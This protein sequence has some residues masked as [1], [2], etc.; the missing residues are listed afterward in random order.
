MCIVCK[1]QHSTQTSRHEA[2]TPGLRRT[3]SASISSKVILAQLIPILYI[4]LSCFVELVDRDRNPAAAL[5]GFYTRPYHNSMHTPKQ[6]AC[7]KQSKTSSRLAALQH[8]I[9]HVLLIVPLAR[10]AG[11]CH[12]FKRRQEEKKRDI[13]QNRTE[14]NRTEQS[15]T[16]QQL[17]STMVKGS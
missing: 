5:H 12:Q 8:T 10:Y 16:E 14:Q 15:K 3:Y 2:F 17:L 11:K 9:V 1:L 13:D 4:L 7:I 6:C